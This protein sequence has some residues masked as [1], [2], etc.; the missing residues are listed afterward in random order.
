MICENDQDLRQYWVTLLPIAHALTVFIAHRLNIKYSSADQRL[1]SNDLIEKAWEVQTSGTVSDLFQDVDVDKEC[2]AQF[3]ELL[4][5]RSA[6]AG[7]AGNRQW[8]LDIGEHQ[9]CWDPYEGL[10]EIWN[11]EGLRVEDEEE[12][13]V[14]QSRGLFAPIR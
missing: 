14:R 12:L 1:T 4:F 8:G 7:V 11:H 6:R 2:L 13:E 10:P 3:E 5:E 9:S